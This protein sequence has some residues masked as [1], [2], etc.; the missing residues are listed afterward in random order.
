MD[1]KG[2]KVLSL[3]D[4]IKIILRKFL[5]LAVPYYLMWLLLWCLT[6]RLGQ[7]PIYANTNITF[8]DCKD[9]WVYTAL[10]VG[11]IWPMDMPPYQ[12]CYQQAFPL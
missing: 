4:I 11:N 7:G 3:L 5:R 2:G 1:A 6:S 8:M 12:G 10:F 9:N